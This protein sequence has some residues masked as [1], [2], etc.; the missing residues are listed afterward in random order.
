[1]RVTLTVD[2][3]AFDEPAHMVVV[4][5]SGRYGHGMPVVPNARL[6]DGILRVLTVRAESKHH[7]VNIVHLMRALPHLL[8]GTHL[9]RGDVV[10]RPGSVVELRADWPTQLWADG[11]V[12]GELPAEVR[13]CPG[14][15]AFVAPLP[16]AM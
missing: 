14:A 13:I 11:E 7:L 10:L 8:A 9:G 1:M 15:L 12:I 5:N 6:D 2:G 4:A 16:A 3:H